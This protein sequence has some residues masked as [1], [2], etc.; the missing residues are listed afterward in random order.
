[1]WACPRS[2]HDAL[3][4]FSFAAF[5][6]A[7]VPLGLPAAAGAAIALAAVFLL[8]FLLLLAVLPAWAGLARHRLAGSVVAGINAAVVGL[9]AARSAEHTSEL[10]SRENL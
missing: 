9:L 5:L 2:L 3:P 10:Q 8:G 6:G 4:I 1:S 7:E